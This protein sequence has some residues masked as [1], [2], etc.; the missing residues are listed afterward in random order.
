MSVPFVKVYLYPQ[1]AHTYHE[2]KNGF[3]LEILKYP[4]DDSCSFKNC[5]IDKLCSSALKFVILDYDR[6]SRSEFEADCVVLLDEVS[7]E[8]EPVTKHLS[9]RKTDAVSIF[10][11]FVESVLFDI[12]TF[13]SVAQLCRFIQGGGVCNPFS[14]F[15]A[16]ADTYSGPCQMSVKES[17]FKNS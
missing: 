4:S 16:I 2:A 5:P 15:Q 10:L 12:E 8:G 11:S 17:F 13:I 14:T 1:A 6:F 3:R 9:I 7:L